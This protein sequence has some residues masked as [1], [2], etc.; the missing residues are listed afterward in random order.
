MW[1]FQYFPFRSLWKQS[2]EVLLAQI[3]QETNCLSLYSCLHF[4]NCS[5]L[6]DSPADCCTS[7]EGHQ[8]P[9][10]FLSSCYVALGTLTHSCCDSLTSH[11]TWKNPFAM[12]L[13]KKAYN[14]ILL[15]YESSWE[16]WTSVVLKDNNS[17]ACLQ[18]LPKT[19]PA[20]SMYL[21]KHTC[22]NAFLVVPSNTC[23][24][25]QL[26]VHSLVFGDQG[27]SLNGD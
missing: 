26:I 6:A 15:S 21:C 22:C 25:R 3:L 16:S 14:F 5:F 10:T 2:R 18:T 17:A 20:S 27:R 24:H 23:V 11:S 8:S 9:V 4:L 13:L 7:V 19:S 12:Q 1:N